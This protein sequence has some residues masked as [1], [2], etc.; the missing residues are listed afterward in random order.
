MVVITSTSFD[1]N[2]SNYLHRD[3]YYLNYDDLKSK[4]YNK[5][6]EIR[7]E[8]LNIHPEFVSSAIRIKDTDS[9]PNNI[10]QDNF[11]ELELQKTNSRFPMV[12]V[13]NSSSIFYSFFKSNNDKYCNFPALLTNEMVKFDN[14]FEKLLARCTEQMQSLISTAKRNP[15]EIDD[16]TVDQLSKQQKLRMKKLSTERKEALENTFSVLYDELKKIESYRL[17][18]LMIC[19]KLLLK[20]DKYFKKYS[21]SNTVY[22]A[23]HSFLKYGTA[24]ETATYPRN[25]D[26]EQQCV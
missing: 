3:W 24:R 19:T 10:V 21:S 15:F 4:I 13:D 6:F 12:N 2:Y 5:Y 26:V 20:H 25:V 9:S 14:Y 18:N 16:E 22:I 17:F 11:H 23:A 7:Y 8:H 1:S